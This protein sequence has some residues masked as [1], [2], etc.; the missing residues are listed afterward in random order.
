MN[1]YPI[2]YN[3]TERIPGDGFWAS[4]RV[5]G[6]AL[7]VQEDDQEWWAYGVNPGAIAGGGASIRAAFADLQYHFRQYLADVAASATTEDAF[8]REL[9][10]FHNECDPETLAEWDAAV[11]AI[12]TGQKAPPPGMTL[13]PLNQSASGIYVEIIK[14][15]TPSA[16]HVD[17]AV[18]IAA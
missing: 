14:R 3:F 8:K 7:A 11:Q 18:A 16:A 12:R 13:Q 17:E 1:T 2:L 15:P 10:R 9:E 5:F 4:V 6:R